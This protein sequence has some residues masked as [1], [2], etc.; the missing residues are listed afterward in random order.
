MRYFLS[1]NGIEHG[2]LT[3]PELWA[4]MRTAKWLKED[5]GRE[6]TRARRETETEWLPLDAFLE[7]EKRVWERSWNGGARNEEMTEADRDATHRYVTHFQNA[8]VVETHRQTHRATRERLRE[9]TAYEGTR[10]MVNVATG[11]ALFFVLISFILLTLPGAVVAVNGNP[12]ASGGAFLFALL[13]TAFGLFQVFLLRALAIALL[14]GAD[15]GI[16]LKTDAEKTIEKTAK[17]ADAKRE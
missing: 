5:A 16:A 15:A 17:N 2:P 6:A 12:A 13:C 10:L 7:R 1:H 14:D 4:L 9:H 3:P 11:V 8:Q